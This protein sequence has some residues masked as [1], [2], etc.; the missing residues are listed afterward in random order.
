MIN[1]NLND[2]KHTLTSK[3]NRPNNINEYLESEVISYVKHRESD[4]RQAREVAEE[5]W[6]EAWSLYTGTPAAVDHQRSQ[7][8]NTVG[9]VNNNWRHRLNTGKAF[10]TVET[11]H[12]YLMGALFPNR[13]WFDLVPTNPGYSQ[14]ARVIRKYLANKFIKSGFKTE[15]SKYLR[16]LLVCGTSILA[17]PWRFEN[18]NI[19]GNYKGSTDF[20]TISVFDVFLDPFSKNPNDADFIR[21]IRKTKADVI[22]NLNSGK[23]SGVD[24]YEVCEMKPYES[25]Y[26][27]KKERLTSFQGIRTT[28]EFSMCDVVEVIEFWGDVHCDGVTLHDVVATVIGDC[29]VSLKPNKYLSG[30]PFVVGTVTQ[31]TETPYS[32]G[33]LQPNLGLMHELNIVTNQRMDCLEIHSNN[34]FTLKE[35]STLAPEDVFV[36]PG[37]VFLVEEHGDL[38]PLNMGNQPFVINYQE[39]AVLEQQIDKNS[40]TGNFISAN[41]QRSG[42]RVTAAEIQAVKDAGG[43]RLSNLHDHIEQ[44]SLIEILKRVWKSTQQFTKE[45]ELV[46]VSGALPGTYDYMKISPDSFSNEY[47]IFPIGADY[48]TD[49]TKFVRSRMEF[50]SFVSQVPEMAA[51]IDYDALLLDVVNH[52]GFDEPMSYIKKEQAQQPQ[53]Q[54]E[55][56]MSPE[57]LA[58]QMGG[59]SLRQV[60]QANMAADGGADYLKRTSGIDITNGTS[61]TTD[62]SAID[63]TSSV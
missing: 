56:Q 40:G 48:V 6:L 60:A 45:D 25:D 12:A 26:N 16:Q 61:T 44:T 15:F 4:F 51:K 8:L 2:F 46:R 62:T 9:N 38:Q 49:N 14:E 42:E 63:P 41:S 28:R 5:T 30:K 7:T 50:M 21:R 32:I 3:E 58:Y 55:S 10:E 1:I 43:N 27:Y 19:K 36:E 53:V 47:S 20:E 39:A 33:L 34:M 59:N 37:K 29:L 11:V 31:I 57:E 18:E 23:Y 52:M 13:E 24:A 17:L 22:N 54:P 35:N